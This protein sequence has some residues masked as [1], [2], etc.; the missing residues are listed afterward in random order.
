LFL[1]LAAD[2]AK[3]IANTLTREFPA[4]LLTDVGLLVAN[5]AF[6]PPTM[7]PSFDRNRY[8]GTVVWSWHHA[9]LRAGLDRQLAREDLP[10]STR[11]TL[12]SARD[13]LLK[14]MTAATELRG[15]ELWSWS[16]SGDDFRIEPFGQA[17]GHETESNAAQLWSAVH[18]AWH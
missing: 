17:K 4:G 6:S 15:S 1:D 12:T 9:L 13:R 14:A 11:D 7:W 10:A 2:E 8:H 18:L 3:R 5:P 16:A